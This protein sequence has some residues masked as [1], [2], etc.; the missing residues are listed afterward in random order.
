MVRSASTSTFTFHSQPGKLSL[1]AEIPGLLRIAG[2]FI[3][4]VQESRAAI[5][6]SIKNPVATV[7]GNEYIHGHTLYPMGWANRY[8]LKVPSQ[9]LKVPCGLSVESPA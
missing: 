9:S 6:L 8:P 1:S 4:A 7:M 5:T 3:S 2:E